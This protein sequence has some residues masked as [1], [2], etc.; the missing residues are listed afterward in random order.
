MFKSK[1]LGSKSYFNVNYISYVLIYLAYS[2]VFVFLNTYFPILFFNVLD[3]NRFMLALLQFFAYSIL[4]LRPVFAAITDKYR[5]KGYQ[6]KYYIIFSCYFF[7]FIYILLGFSFTNILSFS[8]LL[9]LIFLSGTMLDVSTKSLIIDIS[10]TKEKKKQAFYFITFG[11]SLGNALPLFLYLFIINDIYSINSWS[12]L[13]ISSYVILIPL[14]SIVPFIREKNHC[15]SQFIEDAEISDF[16]YSRDL[17]HPPNFKKVL[18]L[19]CIFIFLAF[20][21]VIFVYPFFP[22]LLNKFGT[23]KFNIFNFLLT[24][25]FLISIMSSTIG[26]FIIKRIKPKKIILTLIPIIGSLYILYTFVN[27]TLFILLYFIGCSLATITNLNISVYIMKFK[28]GNKSLYF[29]LIASF[30]NLSFFIFLPLGT[31]LSNFISTEYIIII[32][33]I[34][35]NFSIIPLIFIKV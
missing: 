19:L 6:R 34:L 10:P 14:I 35:L 17:L 20:S 1:R 2:S 32:G 5:I 33:A 31:L 21:D 15:K 18:V 16:N 23:I 30:K 11:Q 12:I 26:T 25:Y 27:F 24:F 3:I 29:H 4:L 28:K 9:L 8:F 7:A 13:F 22:F